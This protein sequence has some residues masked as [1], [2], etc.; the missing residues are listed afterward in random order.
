MVVGE[1]AASPPVALFCS[2]DVRSSAEGEAG[3]GSRR[4]ETQGKQS[5]GSGPG[6]TRA[7]ALRLLCTAAAPGGQRWAPP[8]RFR[9]SRSGAGPEEL[10]F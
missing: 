2:R 8:Q 5:P 3:E 4:E 9:L 7:V 1:S 10:H 6:G